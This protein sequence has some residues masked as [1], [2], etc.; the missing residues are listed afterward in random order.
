MRKVRHALAN[1]DR[2]FMRIEGYDNSKPILLEDYKAI[3]LQIPKVASTAMKKLLRSELKVRGRGAHSSRFP[4]ADPQKL[5]NG[6][7]ADYFRFGFFITIYMDFFDGV[8]LA[9]R[10]PYGEKEKN[11][12]LYQFDTQNPETKEI[13]KISLA[14]LVNEKINQE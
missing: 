6:G 7:Y 2:L 5:N 14:Y 11:L 13:D 4:L 3:Y 8:S 9:K 12:L 10:T 1:L